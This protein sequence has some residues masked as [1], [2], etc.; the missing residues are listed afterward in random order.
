MLPA[1]CAATVTKR[2]GKNSLGGCSPKALLALTVKEWL[3]IGVVL[4]ASAEG[5]ALACVSHQPSTLHFRA[6]HAFGCDPAHP[7]GTCEDFPYGLI[8]IVTAD[9]PNNG[10]F[11]CQEG[12]KSMCCS[13]DPKK[14]HYPAKATVDKACKSL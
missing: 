14:G 9:E 11:V 2:H 8:R 10:V 5:E 1:S 12:K 7:F 6:V 4:A 13:I 3:L